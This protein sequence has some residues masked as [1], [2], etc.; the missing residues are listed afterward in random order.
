VLRA[1]LISVAPLFF[2]FITETSLLAQPAVSKTS[3]PAAK[4][5]AIYR[6]ITNSQCQQKRAGN[7]MMTCYWTDSSWKIT[8][9]WRD[10]NELVGNCSCYTRGKAYQQV[11]HEGS[12]AR[13]N[14]FH[15][16]LQE[17]TAEIKRSGSSVE[18]KREAMVKH[19]TLSIH[20]VAAQQTDGIIARESLPI[21][22][23]ERNL[24][25]VQQFLS[26]NPHGAS[27]QVQAMAESIVRDPSGDSLHLSIEK[28]TEKTPMERMGPSANFKATLQDPTE[29]Q[30]LL[31]NIQEKRKYVAPFL[32][33]AQKRIVAIQDTAQEKQR[34]IQAAGQK[35]NL[36]QFRSDLTAAA[37]R[38]APATQVNQARAVMSLD[39][40]IHGETEAP[41]VPK[42]VSP[43]TPAERETAMGD[44][45]PDEDKAIEETDAD[46]EIIAA[47]LALESDKP[48]NHTC[49][50]VHEKLLQS[51]TSKNLWPKSNIMNENSRNGRSATSNSL[52][53]EMTHAFSAPN[54]ST[55]EFST[56]I[57][58]TTEV[59]NTGKPEWVIER[60]DKKPSRSS[61]QE[62]GTEP[63]KF[64]YRFREVEGGRC[65]MISM[66]S[67]D[68]KGK[69]KDWDRRSCRSEIA[70]IRMFF[71]AVLGQDRR[72]L[73]NCSF[74]AGLFD[75]NAAAAESR[76]RN[77]K[78]QTTPSRRRRH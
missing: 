46:S 62:R 73:R 54:G 26:N 2:L 21:N 19:D 34:V 37:N 64:T 14:T 27:N 41:P 12:Q 77:E 18:G 10:V 20:L 71:R 31:L 49:K 70:P 8:Y 9:V 59:S 40:P 76:V 78:P 5:I 44:S 16:H 30:A 63:I 3:I 47:E 68:H 58:R 4:P 32:S 50:E 45:K 60:T 56:R 51:V 38:A 7:P 6:G 72:N 57:D 24:S 17:T 28:N 33:N 75:E 55:T 13:L 23:L 69:I 53:P 67:V 1:S 61:S 36:D 39:P 22:V 74:A 25:G 29:R 42:P 65:Q 52:L 35:P 43:V 11:L 66:Q 15:A 48:L